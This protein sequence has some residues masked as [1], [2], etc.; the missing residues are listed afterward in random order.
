[1][2]RWKRRQNGQQ[3]ARLQDRHVAA[4]AAEQRAHARRLT[5]LRNEQEAELQKL[6]CQMAPII[7]KLIDVR[8]D[9]PVHRYRVPAPLATKPNRVWHVLEEEEKKVYTRKNYSI[10]IDIA[11]DLFMYSVGSGG[12]DLAIRHVAR[13]AEDIV[14]HELTKLNSQ[15]PEA[16]EM[17]P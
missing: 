12:V 2:K 15:G 3:I 8:V 9:A 17:K 5:Q 11:P 7:D 1:M 4:I 13:R 14:Y 10:C 6:R 16:K